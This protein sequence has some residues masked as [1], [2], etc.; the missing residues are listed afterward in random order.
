MK[1]FL[2]K[3]VGKKI[4][5]IYAILAIFGVNLFANA[6]AVT[7]ESKLQVQNATTNA[8]GDYTQSITASNGQLARFS[9]WYHNTMNENSGLNANNVV[10]KIALPSNVGTSHTATST[11]SGGNTN[12]VTATATVNTPNNSK[13]EYVP[14]YAFRRYNKGTN[15]NQQWVTEKISDVVVSGGYVIVQMK[16]CWNFQET[17]TVVTRVI[18]QAQPVAPT[19]TL[20]ASPSTIEKGQNAALTYGTTNATSVTINGENAITLSGNRTVT[21]A[22]TTQYHL[23]ATGDG[24]SVSC[25][26]IVR[27]TTK[28]VPPTP[29]PTPQPPVVYT[30]KGNMPVS[31]PAEAAAGAVGLTA[32]GGAAYAWLRSKKALLG[33]L[34]NI[35]K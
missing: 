18:D 20:S 10:V 27:V 28:P 12:S 1:K 22:Q 9:V 11:V 5:A 32:T 6:A 13:L 33:A 3:L 24:G 15:T 35:K 21:P 16:P 25:D 26:A 23:V 31:G 2:S 17:I 7:L 19:C 30:G 14:G 34:T 4:L 8:Y 29:T